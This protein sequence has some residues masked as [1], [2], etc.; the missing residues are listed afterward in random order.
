MLSS[1]GVNRNMIT[2]F[3]DGYYEE[4]LYVTKLFGIQGIQ[5]MPIG[6]KNARVSQHYKATIT[7][8]FKKFENAKYIIIL[9]EDLDVSIDFF[10]Y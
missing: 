8:T 9:E 7:S 1:N 5:H 6:K 4:P 3:I 2:V 10:R